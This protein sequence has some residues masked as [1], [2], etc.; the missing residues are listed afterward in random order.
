LLENNKG[1]SEQMTV[2]FETSKTFGHPATNISSK[3][4]QAICCPVLPAVSC[5]VEELWSKEPRL[6]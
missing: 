3:Q 2:I 6:E 5:H 1:L 4:L